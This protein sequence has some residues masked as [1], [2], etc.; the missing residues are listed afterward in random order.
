MICTTHYKHPFQAPR[1]WSYLLFVFDEFPT[2]GVSILDFKYDIILASGSEINSTPT[3]FVAKLNTSDIDDVIAWHQIEECTHLHEIEY[4]SHK[5][6]TLDQTSF[7]SSILVRPNL[8]EHCS[9]PT[10]V[11]IHGG[12]HSA[13][14][15]SYLPNCIFYA[16]LGLKTLLINYRG[17]TGVDGDYINKLSGNVGTMDV[18]DC[19]HVIRHLVQRGL[20]DSSKLAIQ[21]GSHGGFIAAHLSC[22]R[23]F[24]FTSAILRNPVIDIS[25]LFSTS[26]IP[27]WGLSVA[28]GHKEYRH[29]LMPTKEE[30]TKM[31]ECS[32]IS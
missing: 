8:R 29:D 18:D 10:V 1:A 21:G 7:V 3:V 24:Q 25:T 11:I 13:F 32:P 22:Q 23:E 26:D 27:D 4:E 14:L 17:S 16:R 31:F 28:L 20:V 2:T 30:L 9:L 6:P 12:P 19:L 15:Q 5:I